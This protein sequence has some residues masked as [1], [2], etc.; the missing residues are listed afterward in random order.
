MSQVPNSDT[1]YIQNKSLKRE[2]L[3]LF[4]FNIYDFTYISTSAFGTTATLYQ[5][6]RFGSIRYHLLDFLLDSYAPNGNFINNKW[7]IKLNYDA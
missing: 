1:S 5:Y 4:N 6:S 2:L 3:S 7:V